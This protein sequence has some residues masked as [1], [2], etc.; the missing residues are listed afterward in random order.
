MLHGARLTEEGYLGNSHIETTHFKKGLPR[1]GH[2]IT[3]TI[4]LISATRVPSTSVVTTIRRKKWIW[5]L[6]VSRKGSWQ[7][8][9]QCCQSAFVPLSLNQLRASSNTRIFPII[10]TAGVSSPLYWFEIIYSLQKQINKTFWCTIRALFLIFVVLKSLGIPSW[11]YIEIT[12]TFLFTK[13]A[14][15]SRNLHVF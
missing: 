14:S 11:I 13:T 6:C 10:Q 9:T 2:S 1:P 8:S 5:S 7:F 3:N 4:N 12:N 15:K